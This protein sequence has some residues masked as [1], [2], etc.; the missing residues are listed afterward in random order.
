VAKDLYYAKMKDNIKNLF[1]G[2]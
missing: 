1:C 2:R